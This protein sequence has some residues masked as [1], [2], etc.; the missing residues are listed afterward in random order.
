L[1]R[2]I[3]EANRYLRLQ[4]KGSV[5]L[6]DPKPFTRR[7]I[8]GMLAEAFP[9]YSVL[10]EANSE[11]L[12]SK[13]KGLQLNK[14]NFVIIYIR[15]AS[16]SDASVQRSLKLLSH[17][18]PR[19]PIIFLSD[20]PNPIEANKAFIRGVRGSSRLAARRS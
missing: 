10:A 15:A 14:L 5:A 8:T 18:V 1:S 4:A 19:V 20:H 7:L 3:M 6:I 11:E 13:V 9:E 2:E 17:D 16:F 12:L